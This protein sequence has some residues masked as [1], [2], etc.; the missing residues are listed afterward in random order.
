MLT[1]ANLSRHFQ[2]F[3]KD[4]K[5]QPQIPYP[6]LRRTWL[7]W[8][9]TS[10]GPTLAILAPWRRNIGARSQLSKC[11]QQGMTAH[12][13]PGSRHQTVYSKMK[14]TVKNT[15]TQTPQPLISGESMNPGT[16][17][18]TMAKTMLAMLGGL[19]L[20]PSP[21]SEVSFMFTEICV[22]S[23]AQSHWRSP[24]VLNLVVLFERNVK[25]WIC[26]SSCLYNEH[27]F[28]GMLGTKPQKKFGSRSLCTTIKHQSSRGL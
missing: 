5:N 22:K 2:L 8:R 4:L 27:D 11:F 6:S 23:M 19:I 7:R 16:T 12:L 20:Q 10:P 26:L 24:V 3:C 9:R 14:P 28:F 15:G 25:N 21:R 1:K 18:C 17:V 13:T